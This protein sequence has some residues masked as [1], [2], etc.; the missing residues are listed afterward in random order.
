MSAYKAAHP[1]TTFIL[2]HL[3]YHYIIRS[4]IFCSATVVNTAAAAEVAKLIHAFLM[5]PC[6]HS[7]SV[8][9]INTEMCDIDGGYH[10]P[11][12]LMH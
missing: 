6:I 10:L 11:L 1:L 5:P 3:L 12:L 8:Q 9:A 4:S 7:H 2:H